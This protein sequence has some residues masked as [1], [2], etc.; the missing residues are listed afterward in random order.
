MT[1][2]IILEI[3]K[4]S[5]GEISLRI[6][7]DDQTANYIVNFEDGRTLLSDD[8]ELLMRD[9]DFNYHKAFGKVLSAYKNNQNIP[10]PVDLFTFE[11]TQDLLAA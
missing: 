4:I 7:T 1:E 2:F 6:K 10:L 5:S 8:L 11:V 3:K 9:K